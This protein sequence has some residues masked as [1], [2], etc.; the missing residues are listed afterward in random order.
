MLLMGFMLVF[1]PNVASRWNVR[2]QQRHIIAHDTNIAA[3]S[4]AEIDEHFRR[5]EEFNTYLRDRQPRD[6]LYVGEAADLPEDY[7]SI[8]NINGIMGRL[9]I[10]SVNINLPI[11]HGTTSAALYR[12]AGLLEG[13]AFP[14]G[15][16]GNHPVIIAHSGMR[17]APLFNNLE[18]IEVGDIFFIIVL[19]RRMAYEVDNISIVLPHELSELQAIPDTDVVTLITSIPLGI[20]S[21]RLLVR[22]TRIEYISHTVTQ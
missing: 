12:G 17:H 11:L 10:P 20:N 3:L 16:Y 8:L 21:H 9:E 22:G 1:Y 18:H 4:Q 6:T 14:I 2:A 5:A 15:G 19:D 7:H 13:T